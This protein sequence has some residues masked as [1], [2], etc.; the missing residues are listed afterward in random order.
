MPN[1]N[2]IALMSLTEAREANNNDEPWRIL[3]QYDGVNSSNVS[4]KSSKWWE[5]WCFG[6]GMQT[7]YVNFGKNG[8]DGRTSPL[9]FTRIDVLYSRV[10]AKIQEGYVNAVGQ[11][12][13]RV[14]PTP[15]ALLNLPEP[16]C[17]I[18]EIRELEDNSYMAY[19]VKGQVLLELPGSGVYDLVE[20]VG[21]VKLNR[22]S[23]RDKDKWVLPLNNV[24]G[25]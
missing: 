9:E 10:V 18:R 19:D 7:V 12:S 17:N 8:T 3:Y 25:M 24:A 23:F 4:G 2:N 16:Y 11:G 6:G 15:K 20:L 21:F 14:Q 22:T 5:A 13:S 1:Q